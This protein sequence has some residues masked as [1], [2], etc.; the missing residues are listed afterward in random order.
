[1]SDWIDVGVVACVFFAAAG[2]MAWLADRLA[3]SER[4]HRRLR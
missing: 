4:R 2:L 1:M 3:A